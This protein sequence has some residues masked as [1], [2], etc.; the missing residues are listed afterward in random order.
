MKGYYKLATF[1]GGCFWC[2][3]HPFANQNG[4]IEVISGYTGG[5]EKNPSYED[6]CMGKTGHFEAVQVTY[7]PKI[8]SYKKLLDTFW[9]Q[10][11]PTDPIGQFADKGQQYR[12]AVFYHDEEQKML[13]EES[14]I[15]LDKSGKFD[16]PI[17]T[18]ILPYSEFYPAE[19]YHQNYYKK[20][21]QYYN[22]YKVGS[23]RDAFLKKTWQHDGIG[24]NNYRIPGN[25]ELKKRLSPMQYKVTRENYTEP[26]F[27]NEYWNNKRQGIYVDI[28]SGEP[29]FSSLDKFDS[30]CGWPSFSKPLIYENIKEKTDKSHFMLRTEVRSKYADSH[31]G[32]VFKDGPKPTGLRYCINSSALKFIS[33]ENMKDEGY[34][35][36]LKMFEK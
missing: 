1:A 29:L 2:M 8:I 11:D 21:P 16:K 6:V 35:E 5:V 28:V 34:G 12:T 7:D 36:Y 23:G 33:I 10:I 30:G 15:N 14:K 9:K 26:A 19:E 32:H 27:Q 25:E 3:V 4:V 17:V 31:L 24:V 22:N 13:A 18:Q 20:R